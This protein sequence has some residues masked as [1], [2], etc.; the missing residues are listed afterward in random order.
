MVDI[1]IVLGI[2]CVIL[3]F[4]AKAFGKI[5]QNT[6]EKRMEPINKL[7]NEYEEKLKQWCTENNVIF[8]ENITK[9]KEIWVNQLPGY[10]WFSGKDILFCPDSINCGTS[11]NIEDNIMFIKYNSIK[12]YTKDGIINY[13]NEIIDDGKNISISGAIVGGIIAGEAGAVIGSRKDMNKIKNVTVEHDDVYTYIYCEKND[14]VKLVEI[15]GN[16]FYQRIL[17]LMPEKEYHYVLNKNNI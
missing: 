14:E 15:K 1:M 7:N 6:I 2:I 5:N 13:T 4:I 10:I 12:Y 3:Y 9:T 17:H 11:I 16:E 8:K